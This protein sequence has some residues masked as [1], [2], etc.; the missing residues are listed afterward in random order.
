[1]TGYRPVSGAYLG[2]FASKLAVSF[3]HSKALAEVKKGTVS[4]LCSRQV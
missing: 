1:M 4:H 3:G 2:L